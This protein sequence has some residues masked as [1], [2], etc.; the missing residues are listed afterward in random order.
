[1]LLLYSEYITYVSDSE[2]VPLQSM[3]GIGQVYCFDALTLEK[4]FIVITYPVP[5]VGEHG[6][7]GINTG[8]GPL[9]V[10]PR[11]LAYS[12]NRPFYLNTGRVSSK[13]LSSSASPSTS[14]GNGTMMARYAVESS[15][16]L[17]AGLLTLG[18]L[19]YEK[20]SKYYP[21]LLP[22]SP[23]SPGWISGK[24][25]ASEPENAGMVSANIDSFLFGW[26]K[27]FKYLVF[28]ILVEVL[29]EF[30]LQ[31]AVKDLVCS[32]VISQFRAHTSPISALCFDPS[33]TLL[34]TASLH[35]NNLNIFRIMP[36]HKCGGSSSGDWSTSYVHLYK[37]HRGITNAVSI[38][39]LFFVIYSVKL[40]YPF[41]RC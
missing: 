13:S 27:E 4:K 23:S 18:D 14:P 38:S 29:T 37:L 34:V 8:Y 7:Y 15:K 10:G 32:E 17:A 31:I 6:A 1:M 39:T 2:F 33:G 41:E 26:T 20:L 30:L 5:R 28:Q 9:A 3:C 22:D 21:K 16:H 35:G 40:S 19:G 25:V 11:W 36:C 12:P 24:L